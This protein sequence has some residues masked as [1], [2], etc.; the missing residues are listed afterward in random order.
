MESA[1]TECCIDP[2]VAVT[3]RAIFRFRHFGIC[4][5]D[6]DDDDR[7]W[8]GLLPMGVMRLDSGYGECRSKDRDDQGKSRGMLLL[9]ALLGALRLTFATARSSG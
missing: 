8:L 4:D 5:D 2:R 1:C 7:E 3:R 6:D 9:G